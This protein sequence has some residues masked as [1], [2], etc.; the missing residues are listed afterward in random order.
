MGALATE[1]KMEPPRTYVD[2]ICTVVE[3]TNCGKM[4]LDADKGTVQARKTRPSPEGGLEL[5]HSAI[6][7]MH[8]SGPGN[9]MHWPTNQQAPGRGG[10]G[11]RKRAAHNW[12]VKEA[13]ACPATG[14]ELLPEFRDR[15]AGV[16]NAPAGMPRTTLHK[17]HPPDR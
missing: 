13:D 9:G 2:L 7:T 10:R 3:V 12:K 15:D 6:C 8:H 4:A 5:K 11:A 16:D 14:G 17:G 1:P